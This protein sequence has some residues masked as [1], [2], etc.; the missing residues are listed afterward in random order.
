M[1]L[2]R[3]ARAQRFTRGKKYKVFWGM[4][5]ASCEPRLIAGSGTDPTYVRDC[6]RHHRCQGALL[7]QD[8]MS[9]A[10]LYNSQPWHSVRPRGSPGP[11]EPLLCLFFQ[12]LKDKSNPCLPS[13]CPLQPLL[14]QN[15]W[16]G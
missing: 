16:E 11:A 5:K 3:A 10:A 15:R 4:P 12:A 1:A 13:H 2:G 8:Q 14:L 6:C 7:P 9:N